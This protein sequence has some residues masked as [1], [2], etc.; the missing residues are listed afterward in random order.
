MPTKQRKER[1]MAASKEMV[2]HFC[3]RYAMFTRRRLY[4][5]HEEC[6][7]VCA[8]AN[9]DCASSLASSQ[10]CFHVRDC[11]DDNVERISIACAAC[12]TK[13]KCVFCWI[14][15]SALKRAFCSYVS[16]DGAYYS[17]CK[18]CCER[19]LKFCD[20]AIEQQRKWR[21]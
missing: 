20:M 21:I 19:S 11:G 3:Q 5:L 18:H 16:Y 1:V 4:V 14:C 17:Y 12:V 15:G 2:H 8:C 6:S 7:G 10:Q 13:E 9:I